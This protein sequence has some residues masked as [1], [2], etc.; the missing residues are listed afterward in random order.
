[1]ILSVDRI[2]WKML[3]IKSIGKGF[4]EIY[5]KRMFEHNTN[6][7]WDIFLNICL[8][9]FFIYES[10][11]FQFHWSTYYRS[12]FFL[13]KR[14]EIIKLSVQHICFQSKIWKIVD[15]PNIRWYYIPNFWSEISYLS[16]IY[17]FKWKVRLWAKIEFCASQIK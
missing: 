7:G 12:V 6:H 9:M 3:K 10:N 14:I 15:I 4:K 2:F 11:L 5:F 13:K 16:R 1:M 17:C 8:I